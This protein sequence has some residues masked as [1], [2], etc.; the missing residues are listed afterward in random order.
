MKGVNNDSI[1]KLNVLLVDDNRLAREILRRI[2]SKLG[3]ENIT[4]AVD[5]KEAL[6]FLGKNEID[7]LLTDINM[8]HMNG[9]ELLKS[10]R[11]GYNDVERGLPTIIVTALTDVNTLGLAISLD[12]NGFL[13][14]PF[15]PLGVIQ[16]ILKVFAEGNADLRVKS[17]YL[18]CSTD[19]KNPET[20]VSANSENRE[21]PAESKVELLSVFGLQPG[22]I[23]AEDVTG[24]S[25][26]LLLSKG[27]LLTQHS[28]NRLIELGE[29]VNQK[30]YHV[31]RPQTTN[32]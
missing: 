21:K 17:Y 27:F 5:G 24:S 18:D 19:P 23:L 20:A 22:M 15:K 4:T 31:N 13:T 26:D 3:F 32:G 9:L 25:G 28:I 12:V 1:G 8:P 29:V 2:L 10:I 30:K 6:E 7:L 11:C 14:K 16:E